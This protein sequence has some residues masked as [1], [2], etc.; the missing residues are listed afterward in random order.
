MHA[1]R[2]RYPAAS[3]TWVGQERDGGCRRSVL[4]QLKKRRGHRHSPPPL[5]SDGWG[6][7]DEALV[8]VWG[9]VPEYSGRG[10]PP[11]KKRPQAGWRYLQMVKQRQKGRV[12]GVEAKTI[13]GDEREVRQLLGHSTSYVERTHL[14]SRHMRTV[15]W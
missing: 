2:E 14:S 3:G 11:T 15:G 7:Y 6:G 5:V 10:R 8:E 13:Y 1:D 4:E 12:V 9:E